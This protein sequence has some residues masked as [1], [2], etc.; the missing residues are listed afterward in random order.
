MSKKLFLVTK[1]TNE[2]EVKRTM[3]FIQADNNTYQLVRDIC[4]SFKLDKNEQIRIQIRCLKEGVRNLNGLH[5]FSKFEDFDTH[6]HVLLD[7]VSNCK[8]KKD[9]HIENNIL[10]VD[11]QYYNDKK[12]EDASFYCF[13]YIVFKQ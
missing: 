11:I 1:K 4:C 6:S 13:P 8:Y 7:E 10:S 12:D 5:N 3:F 2:K 9:I